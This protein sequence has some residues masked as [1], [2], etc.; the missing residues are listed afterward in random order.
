MNL[1]QITKKDDTKKVNKDYKVYTDKVLKAP[2]VNFDAINS[3]NW[4]IFYLSEGRM[5]LLQLGN[6]LEDTWT[7]ILNHDTSLEFNDL[8]MF[9]TIRGDALASWLE[10]IDQGDEANLI[11]DNVILTKYQQQLI[12]K[13]ELVEEED[14]ETEEAADETV[15]TT[16]VEAESPPQQ[17]QQRQNQQQQQR[18]QQGQQNQQNQQR[19][20]QQRQNQQQQR[21]QQGQQ[22]QNQQHQRSNEF[23]PAKIYDGFANEYNKRS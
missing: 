8:H 18:Q 16:E 14:D 21:Q 20:N 19:Q 11:V 10:T 22:R 1:D 15:E 12:I 23:D 3:I 6:Q 5:E 2:Q 4:F 7:I 13:L 17:N 9:D